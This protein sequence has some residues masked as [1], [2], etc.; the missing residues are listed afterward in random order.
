M[1]EKKTLNEKELDKVNG[2]MGEL[3]SAAASDPLKLRKPIIMG[4][5]DSETE[6]GGVAE[7]R[8]PT[9]K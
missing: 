1:D 8:R 3:N 6:L 2:G 5:D 4:T 9:L 7:A